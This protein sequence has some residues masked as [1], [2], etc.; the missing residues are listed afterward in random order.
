[1]RL[2]RELSQR[3]GLLPV[4]FGTVSG[5]MFAAPMMDSN[6]RGSRGY[7]NIRI[8]NPSFHVAGLDVIPPFHERPP[9]SPAS[10]I[11]R[12]RRSTA[13]SRRST[14]SSSASVFSVAVFLSA[15]G[16]HRSSCSAQAR[17]TMAA[18]R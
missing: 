12:F 17:Q 15:D 16:F 13:R 18:P 7:S 11:S 8:V 14:I 10:E 2:W 3:Q 4:Y 6:Q 5:A 9:S 1:M